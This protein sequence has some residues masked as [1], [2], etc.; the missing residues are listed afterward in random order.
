MQ[1]PDHVSAEA[2]E[3]I[4]R[5]LRK[6]PSERMK[7]H[8]VLDHPFVRNSLMQQDESKVKSPWNLYLDTT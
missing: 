2:R 8:D 6:N 3:L 4:Q 7:L 1:I 5:L